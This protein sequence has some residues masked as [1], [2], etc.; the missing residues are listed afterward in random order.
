[1]AESSGM[2]AIG[3]AG[4]V[5]L[6]SGGVEHL[7]AET[8]EEAQQALAGARTRGD[9]VLVVMEESLAFRIPEEVALFRGIV[10]EPE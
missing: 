9:S 4:M 1:M 5:F 6:R 8:P 2:L 7:L 10:V 3:S